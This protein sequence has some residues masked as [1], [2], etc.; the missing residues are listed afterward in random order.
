MAYTAVPGPGSAN[1]IRRGERDHRTIAF[2]ADAGHAWIPRGR[3]KE[4]QIHDRR[5]P[6]RPA[7]RRN[8]VT[9]CREA[10]RSQGQALDWAAGTTSTQPKADRGRRQPRPAPA[11]CRLSDTATSSA[12]TDHGRPG[13]R[14]R[15]CNGTSSQKRTT[16]GRAA[17]EVGGS[18]VETKGRRGFACR[19][20]QHGERCRE[21]GRCG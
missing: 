2:R 20:E 6:R 12:V 17:D 21:V 9:V 13:E 8:P 3:P 7:T 14:G 5:I 11:T 15:L 4:R 18:G 16:T 10:S 1:S 19:A